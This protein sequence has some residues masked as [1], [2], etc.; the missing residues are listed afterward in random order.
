MFLEKIFAKVNVDYEQM[1]GASMVET[2][3][4]LLGVPVA[5]Y[6]MAAQFACITGDATTIPNSAADV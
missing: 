6:S 1:N 5:E 2:W 4:F 3:D